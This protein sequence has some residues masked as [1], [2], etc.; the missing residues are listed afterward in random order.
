MDTQIDTVIG[1]LLSV[2][3]YD[4]G[5]TVTETI[6]IATTR[7]TLLWNCGGELATFG[8]QKR[9]RKKISSVLQVSELLTSMSVETTVLSSSSK[10]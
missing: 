2:G 3:W 5:Q 10:L 1:W 7:S 4:N 9:S 8:D 6:R